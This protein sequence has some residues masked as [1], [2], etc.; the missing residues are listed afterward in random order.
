MGLI[1]TV[2]FSEAATQGA[3]MTVMTVKFDIASDNEA[4]YQLIYSKFIDELGRGRGKFQIAF[5]DN[6]YFVSTPENIHDF[7]RRLLNKT[8]FRIDK[9]RLTV[10]DERSKKIFICG[11]CDMDIFAK[12]PEFQ[13]ISITE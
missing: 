11:A 13:L 9:D 10:I 5:K 4:S 7:V 8:D 1:A 2:N 6:V 3:G 12:F